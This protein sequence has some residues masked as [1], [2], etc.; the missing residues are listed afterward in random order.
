MGK[1]INNPDATVDV[2]HIIDGIANG[3]SKE[4]LNDLDN[5]VEGLTNDQ[6]RR[7]VQALLW[8]GELDFSQ[9]ERVTEVA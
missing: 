1:N 7:V 3:G 5:I 9:I 4:A 2:Q 6:R 8:F